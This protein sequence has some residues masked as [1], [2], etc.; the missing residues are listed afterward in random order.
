MN[1]IINQRFLPDGSGRVCIHLFAHSADGS[2][3]TPAGVNGFK[4]EGA[5]G[6]IACNPTQSKVTPLVRG[7][8][9]LL[10][11]WSDDAR[12]VS[13]PKCQETAEFKGQMEQ[14]NSLVGSEAAAFAA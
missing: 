2:A 3:T 14:L 5:R 4:F 1:R 10:C 8:E 12:A 11:T 6:Y 7:N 9:H 13:C